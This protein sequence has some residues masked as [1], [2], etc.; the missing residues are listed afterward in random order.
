MAPEHSRES[1]PIV[2]TI[3]P[4]VQAQ[5]DQLGSDPARRP[6]FAIL[7]DFAGS[8]SSGAD[9]ILAH[10]S[11]EKKQHLA[12]PAIMCGAFTIELLL[13]ALVAAA[14]PHIT[15][16]AELEPL[17]VNLQGHQYSVLYD[18]I[19]QTIQQSI[20]AVFSRRTGRA[21]SPD[22]FRDRLIELGD[23]PF[24]NWRYVYERDGWHYIDFKL[25]GSILLKYNS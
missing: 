24:V 14:Q 12:A 2:V 20:A 19:N 7:Y 25:L 23:K 6:V 8:Y 17:G 18:R 15:L 21:T 5:L 9:A 22:A 4:D 13:K 10:M 1:S 11:L 16:Y 3:P